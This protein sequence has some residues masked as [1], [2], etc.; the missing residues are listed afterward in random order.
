M[1]G[2]SGELG[3]YY[4]SKL[5]AGARLIETHHSRYYTQA[6]TARQTLKNEFTELLD[7]VDVL[8]YPSAPAIAPKFEEVSETPIDFACNTRQATVTRFPA[9]TLPSGEHQGL[10]TSLQLVAK[11]FQ[12]AKLLGITQTVHN[13]LDS[14][15]EG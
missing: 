13:F 10:P 1:E 4:K 11:P 5:L 3:D 7:D 9:M 14:P 8:L 2:A 6:Q 15:L 12:E